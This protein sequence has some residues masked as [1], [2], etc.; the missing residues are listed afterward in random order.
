MLRQHRLRTR[1]AS[2]ALIVL[3]LASPAIGRNIIIMIGDG[4]GPEQVKAGG[5]YKYGAPGTLAFEKLPHA[6][7][8]KTA[9]ASGGVTDSAAAGT[10]IATGVKVKNGTISMAVPGD[11]RELQTL[12]ETCKARGMATGLVTTTALTH[13]TPAAFGAHDRSRK[14]ARQ[15]ANDYLTQTKPDVLLGGGE[16]G[17]TADGARR[18]GYSVVTDLSGLKRVRPGSTGRLAGLFGSSHL[19]Y[20][21]DGLGG[22]PHL[23]DMVTAALGVLER[24]PNGYFLM[25]EGGRIDHACHKNDAERAVREVAAFEEAFSVV[26][27]RVSRR[28]DTLVIVTA[29][30]ETGGLTVKKGNGRGK[31][32]DVKWST[33]NH[34]GKNVPAYAWGPGAEAVTGTIENTDI[35]RIVTASLKQAVSAN[36]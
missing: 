18:A 24:N 10:A 12:L 19:P 13:A 7:M 4:M 35:H 32:P 21:K 16:S 25:I 8:A 14:N 11:G 26:W 6:A 9:P 17:M 1:L 33:K 28:T 15:I 22:L 36:R 31:T 20:E 34:T 5:I 29:D 23:S 2:A 30:H 27:S 3:W